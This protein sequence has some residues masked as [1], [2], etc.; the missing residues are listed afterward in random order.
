M[1]KTYF[2][3]T[4][5]SHY[6]GTDFL[7]KDMIVELEKEPENEFDKEAILVRAE[8]LGKIGYVANSPFTVQGESISA[9]RMY[10]RIGDK[11]TGIVVYV[12]S[13]GVLCK[14]SEENAK[15]E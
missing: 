15:G 10:D 2:T 9:G 13:N 6:F 4:G 7:E 11:A 8:G 14:L 5:T 1:E 12:L 3:L